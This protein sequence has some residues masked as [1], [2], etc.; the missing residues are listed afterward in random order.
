M[1]N[2]ELNTTPRLTKPRPF[3][4]FATEPLH[5]IRANK[6]RNAD[7]PASYNGLIAI[8]SELTRQAAALHDTR[9]DPRGS[10]EL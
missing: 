2:H 10:L 7:E 4:K 3:A 1:Q 5:D 9:G 8:W 6:R